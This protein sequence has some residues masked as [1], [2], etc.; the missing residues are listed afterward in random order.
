MTHSSSLLRTTAA[1][2]LTSL[3]TIGAASAQTITQLPDSQV[4][5]SGRLRIRGSGLG[6]SGTVTVNGAPALTTVWRDNEVHAYVPEATALG[7][8]LVQLTTAGS[9]SN[10]AAF[11]VVPR[12]PDGR[13]QWRFAA[14]SV[15]PNLHGP[16]I[17]PDGT[18]Y[19]DDTDGRLYALAPDGELL[20]IFNG[21]VGVVGGGLE[22]PIDVASDGTIYY[23]TNPLGTEIRVHAVNPDGTAKWMFSEFSIAF[24]VIA[25]PNIGPD[26]NLYLVF[27]RAH[28]GT[29]GACSLDT[30]GNL[31]W[32]NSG[33]PAL[34]D[35][36]SLG[37]RIAFGASAFYVAFN[38][39]NVPGANDNFLFGFGFDGVQQFAVSGAWQTGAPHAR[40]DG[41][42]VLRWGLNTTLQSLDSAG[43]KQWTFNAGFNATEP[44]VGPGGVT[45]HQGSLQTL[46]AIDPDGSVRWSVAGPQLG[47]MNFMGATPTGGHL[48][49]GGN[50]ALGT[51]GWIRSY[52]TTD[53][54]LEWSI[55]LPQED[56]GSG[57][58]NLSVQST[59]AFAPSRAYASINT[60][61]WNT[62]DAYGYLYAI[63]MQNG[64]S[65]AAYCTAGTSASGCQASLTSS[66]VASLS[67]PSGFTV[68]AD[69]VEGDKAG[70]F[71]Y[72]LNGQQANSWGNGTSFQCV[73]SPVTRTP[74]MN[75]SG[76]SGTCDG[77]F[78]LDLNAFWSTA[79]AAKLPTPGQ[80][81]NL[82]LWY[83]D[84]QNSSNQTTSLSDGLN[85]TV[86][87]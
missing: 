6:T 14:S 4:T 45:Y 64:S 68:Q 62:Q 17:G 41:S 29:L 18:L 56:P 24:R 9:T 77:G 3:L 81:V 84:P 59:W 66:G 7:G 20:W 33:S 87:P 50:G 71:F 69:A 51:P 8:A 73:T 21:N 60:L 57:L 28:L 49:D 15:S 78:S 67:S 75:G 10:S 58:A 65:G 74:A 23:A 37:H 40:A 2:I 35:T 38:E 79:S 12:T 46:Y 39:G 16:A 80:D 5:P 76:T 42:M 47:W 55:S 25:G 53:G 44:V 63:D 13:I 32:S 19:V 36:G 83:R 26:G 48:L 30:D 34:N 43:N 52:S 72:G 31:R 22:G 85:F 11:E 1:L 82:Q 61:V 27:D 86:A 70:V 54:A